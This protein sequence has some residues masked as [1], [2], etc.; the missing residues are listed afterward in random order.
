MTNKSVNCKTLAGDILEGG[1][2]RQKDARSINVSFG[3][4]WMQSH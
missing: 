4:H 1:V 3:K 2:G